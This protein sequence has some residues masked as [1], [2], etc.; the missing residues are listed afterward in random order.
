MHQIVQPEAGLGLGI[1]SLKHLPKRPSSA[2]DFGDV[3]SVRAHVEEI[4]GRWE[5]VRDDGKPLTY[6]T[7]S[8]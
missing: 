3:W 6:Y 4:D 1:R 8:E 5:V 2:Y 7:Y